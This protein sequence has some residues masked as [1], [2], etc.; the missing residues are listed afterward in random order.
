MDSFPLRI[1]LVEDNPAEVEFLQELLAHMSDSKL[2]LTPVNYLSEALFYLEHNSFEVI[3][4]DLHLPDSQGLETFFKVK[5]QAPKIPILILSVLND[6]TKALEA[7][8]QGAQ[9]YLIKG[10]FD[11]EL[12]VRAIRYAFERQQIAETLR[13][14]AEREK[15][16][17]IISDKIRHSLDL[18][19]ILQTTVTEVRQFLQADRVAIGNHASKQS[20]V[21]VLEALKSPNSDDYCVWNPQV[22]AALDILSG[23]S[24]QTESF[25]S[26]IEEPRYLNLSSNL[27]NRGILAVPI[28]YSDQDDHD[29]FPKDTSDGRIYSTKLWGIL[30]AHHY[31]SSRQWQC[32]EVDFLQNI[33][34][35][36]AIA[37][38]QSELLHQLEIANRELQ[39]IANIDR[40][41]G[42]ANRRQFEQF[43]KQEWRRLAREKEPLSL[44]L[45]DVDFFKNYNDT[46]GHPAGDECLRQVAQAI[47]TAVKRP[48]DL[49]ARYGGEEFAV[50]LP[51]TDIDGATIVAQAISC[52]MRQQQ[53]PHR[54]STVSQHVTLSIGVASTMPNPAH[55]PETLISKADQ[56]LY[57]AKR[58]GRDRICQAN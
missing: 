6:H 49:V 14:Q 29:N 9:D 45:C 41:T 3:L 56:A 28:W 15:L 31:S 24:S 35:Q 37:I 4:L 32:W 34:N 52:Q 26:Q 38:Q 18:K 46:H 36:L 57:Q 20:W 12:L 1:L 42:V 47:S 2:T 58:Q 40:L 22:S 51:L 27:L 55:Q 11:G 53:L 30:L 44:I 39:R 17:G 10:Q 19:D 43:V 54:S 16:L 7:V 48:G 21:V 8:R 50:I 13:Q 23:F 5:T 33:A 25:P